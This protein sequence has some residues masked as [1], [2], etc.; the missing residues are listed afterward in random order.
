MVSTPYPV[1]FLNLTRRLR[2][3]AQYTLP[4]MLMAPALLLIVGVLC[5]PLGVGI[6]YAFRSM[7][8]DNLFG[9]SSFVG[10]DNFRLLASD[11]RLPNVLYNTLRWVLYSLFFQCALGL[12]LALL[13]RHTRAKG[14]WL[15]TFLFLPWAIP[16]VLTGLIWKMLLSP[17]TSP[18]PHGLA[19]LGILPGAMDILASPDL[20]LYGPVLA[21]VWFGVP[22]F[23]ITLLAALHMIP[24]D[25]YEAAQMDGA[26]GWQCFVRITLP[27]IMPTLLVTL[28]LRSVWI[29]NFGDLIW[30][31][32][33]G[34]PAGATQ[35]MP[36]YLF[37]IAFTDFNE[38]YA[39]ALA[40]AQ[41][42]VLLLYAGVVLRLRQRWLHGFAQE[43]V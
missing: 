32:T 20:A 14:R 21:N 18:L 28:L 12:G 24:N 13:L 8:V 33:Q 10:W 16:S 27:L 17:Q 40:V 42:L 9:E 5:V 41:L 35:I 31:M 19:Q 23:A 39:S 7:S 3:C 37:S 38:G 6:S 11:L 1:F 15:H 25:V 26:S 36:T 43:R 29:V 30:V 2:C 22:F 34:G 4:W